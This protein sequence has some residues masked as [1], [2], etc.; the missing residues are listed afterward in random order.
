MRYDVF[1]STWA[2]AHAKKA[3]PTMAVALQNG[4]MVK[5]VDWHYL[6]NPSGVMA[7]RVP[8]NGTLRIPMR[9]IKALYQQHSTGIWERC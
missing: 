2:K 6:L 9:E 5:V 8:G 1:T 4:D 3:H 7:F